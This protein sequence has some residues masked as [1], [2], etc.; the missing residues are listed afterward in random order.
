MKFFKIFII[1]VIF[2]ITMNFCEVFGSLNSGRFFKFCCLIGS[3][4]VSSISSEIM[5]F[6]MNVINV[7]AV[8]LLPLNTFRNSSCSGLY[9]PYFVNFIYQQGSL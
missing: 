8:Q 3:N 5:N 1:L 4:C 6:S 7:V 9:N 2:S